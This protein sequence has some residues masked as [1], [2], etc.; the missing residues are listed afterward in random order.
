MPFSK[1]FIDIPRISS[2]IL[3]PAP[4]VDNFISVLSSG[5]LKKG[6]TTGIKIARP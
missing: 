5:E 1:L 2:D 4:I 3:I 6:K